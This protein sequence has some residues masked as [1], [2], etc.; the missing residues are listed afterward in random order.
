MSAKLKL[1]ESDPNRLIPLTKAA[2]M[3]GLDPSTLR[4]R[5][6]NTAHLTIIAQGRNLYLVLSEIVDHRSALIENAR[7]KNNI[8]RMMR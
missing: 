7:R 4:Q 2:Q 5:K 3:L 6:A 8:E 1:A